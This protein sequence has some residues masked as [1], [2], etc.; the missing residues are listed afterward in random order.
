MRLYIL[1]ISCIILISYSCGQTES[2][3]SE[4]AIDQ[5]G[6]VSI[7]LINE[8]GMTIEERFLLPEGYE[9]TEA[10]ENSFSSYLGKLPLKPHNSKVKLYNGN[11]KSNQNVHMAVV[12]LEIGTRDLHQCADATIRLRAEYLYSIQAYDKIHFNLT[13]GFRVD[14]SK[15]IRGYRVAVEGN[16]TYWIKSAA[17]SNTYSDL[18]KYLTLIYAYA[19]TLSLSKE[20]KAIEYKDI[21]TGD[22][23]IQGGSPGHA[24]IVVDMAINKTT[25]KRIYLLAQS[26]MPAQEIHVLKNPESDNPWYELNPDD[27]I[28]ETPEW[29]FYSNDLKR[30]GE[31]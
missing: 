2:Q 23:F 6:E 17:P 9:R 12:D 13:N 18:K 20:L 25:G 31:E 8:N 15:W 30:F 19:G 21:S 28:I 11:L 1:K 24:V 29:T 7:N 10:A 16:N 5:P 22:I 3:V 27:T 4:R 26:Y 14:Y